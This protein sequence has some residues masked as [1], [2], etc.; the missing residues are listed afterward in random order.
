MIVNVLVAPICL[1]FFSTRVSNELASAQVKVAESTAALTEL[2]VE[3]IRLTQEAQQAI[4]LSSSITARESVLAVIERTVPT[5]G[6]EIA[7]SEESSDFS[8]EFIVRN[9]ASINVIC[10]RPE[11][12]L[13]RDGPGTSVDSVN[14][15]E[16]QVAAEIGVLS[17]GSEY[18]TVWSSVNKKE[19][20][21]FTIAVE[22]TPLPFRMR[23]VLKMAREAGIDI[24]GIQFSYKKETWT[25]T[26]VAE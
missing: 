1:Y 26:Y 6:V 7:V 2:E 21:W 17:P 3:G 20:F 5:I 18:R 22:C 16:G 25:S 10:K 11:I 24:E 23:E 8:A 15:F 14:I 12:G 13:H 4:T 9:E 19:I